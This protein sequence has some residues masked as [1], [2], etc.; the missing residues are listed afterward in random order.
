MEPSSAPWR[1]IDSVEPSSPPDEERRGRPWLVVAAVLAAVAVGVGALLAAA[2]P[3]PSG[4]VGGIA[5]TEA[6]VA[7]KGGSSSAAPASASRLLVVEVSGAVA[8]PGVFRLP[9]GSRVADA[10][11]AAGGYGPRVDVR[12]ADRVLNLA[13]PLEDGQKVHVPDRD[14]AGAPPAGSGA[15]GPNPTAGGPVDLN[16][17]TETEL[18]ALP[19]IG[20]ATA[21]KIIA[22][23]PYA[24]IDDL[25]S[26]K[27]V[28]AATLAKIRALVTVGG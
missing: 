14:E 24:S 26:R 17:A 10:I 4:D 25:A 28:G 8:R 20:P 12:A 18:D 22:G 15:P 16:R 13:A 21:A 2:K 9:A 6:G 3:A 23:R 19:G 5:I 27:V 11:D 7:D 1:A